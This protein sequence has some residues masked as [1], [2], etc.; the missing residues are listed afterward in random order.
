MGQAKRAAIPATSTSPG[1][2]S[3]SMEPVVSDS[4]EDQKDR[5]GKRALADVDTILRDLVPVHTVDSSWDDGLSPEPLYSCQH[6][7]T[8]CTHW[9]LFENPDKFICSTDKGDKHHRG[10]NA[11]MD[12][13]KGICAKCLHKAGVNPG[14]QFRQYVA[15]QVKSKRFVN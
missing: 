10:G 4:S 14:V 12:F 3:N 2:S 13:W 6:G 7:E 11:L 1:G 5:V 15:N 8:K 9:A